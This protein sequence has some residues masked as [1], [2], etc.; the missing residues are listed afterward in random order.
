MGLLRRMRIREKYPKPIPKPPVIEKQEEEPRPDYKAMFD[1]RKGFW[2]GNVKIGYNMRQP[3]IK[4]YCSNCGKQ[5]VDYD[6]MFSDNDISLCG[7]CFDLF[8]RFTPVLIHHYPGCVE[9]GG[10][11]AI[12]VWKGYDEFIERH[13]PSKGWHYELSGTHI[14]DISDDQK[15]W[16]VLWNTRDDS[17]VK[18]LSE[19][20]PKWKHP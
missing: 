10:E 12:Y 15:E 14:M 5:L 7:R 20:I 4:G 17:I 13:P 11:Y 16:W 2:N 9:N 6:S 3:Q 18:E 8:E 1:A 19:R